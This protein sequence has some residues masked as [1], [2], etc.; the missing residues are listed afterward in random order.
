MA[1]VL[2]KNKC[3]IMFSTVHHKISID[4]DDPKQR[5]EIIK[6]QDSQQD[7]DRMLQTYT[8]RRQTRRWPIVLFYN[9]LDIAA[10][11]PFSDKRVQVMMVVTRE[12]GAVF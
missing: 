11:I 5:P 1:N 8:C 10:I 6:Y 12:D 2:K 3:V 4:E 9:L 7:Q